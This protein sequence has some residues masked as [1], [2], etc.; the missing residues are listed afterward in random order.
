MANLKRLLGLTGAVSAGEFSPSG[1]LISYKGDMPGDVAQL[2][3]K[4]CAANTMMG[5][6]QA[7]SFTRISG[8]KWSPFH[9]WAVA[10][11]D[12]SVCVI[13]NL[14][15]F[16]QTS[17]ADFNDIFRQLSEEAHVELRAA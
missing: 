10:S 9:G 3:A 16:V 8:M 14:G 11:G 15:V 12:Y 17:K 5:I 2:I 7:E 4:M 13:G 1:E 6:S